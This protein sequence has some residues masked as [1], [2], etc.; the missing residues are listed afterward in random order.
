[1]LDKMVR[2]LCADMSYVISQTE[3]IHDIIGKQTRVIRKMK[4]RQLTT[5]VAII[6]LASITI[7]NKLK[8][9][10]LELQIK[11]LQEAK[12]E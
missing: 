1:M 2:G 11:E 8:I 4:C 10:R 12:G 5:A 9:D 7:Q 6:G 3:M